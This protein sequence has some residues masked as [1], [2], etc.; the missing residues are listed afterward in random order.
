MTI[1][2]MYDKINLGRTELQNWIKETNQVH[3]LSK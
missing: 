1:L 3:Y 2:D